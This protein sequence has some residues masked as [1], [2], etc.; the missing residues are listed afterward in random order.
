LAFLFRLV[1][2]VGPLSALKYKD[3]TPQTEALYLKSVVAT[4]NM[5]QQELQ[6]L[7]NSHSPTLSLQN[8]DF[9]T[10]KPTAPGEYRLTDQTHAK[11]ALKLTKKPADPA[12][13]QYLQDYFAKA[14]SVKPRIE[15]KEFWKALA[16]YEQQGTP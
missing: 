3:P 5:Y 1:P 6:E 4:T 13:S 11:L 7:R 16:Q 2:K 9:D 12:L 15:S 14:K 10:G 8:R